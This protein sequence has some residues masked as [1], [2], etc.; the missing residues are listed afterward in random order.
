M[1]PV[2]PM[3]LRPLNALN[4]LIRGAK[5]KGVMAT[6][7]GDRPRLAIVT[8]RVDPDTGQ[9]MMLAITGAEA[10]ELFMGMLTSI[11]G[12]EETR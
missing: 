3:D 5:I 1:M 8:D 11:T 2:E 6:I 9:T 7:G 4:R 10:I 12:P